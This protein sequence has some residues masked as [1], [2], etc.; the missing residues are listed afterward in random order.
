MGRGEA[1]KLNQEDS[2]V[3]YNLLEKKSKRGRKNSQHSIIE[4]RMMRV[5][6]GSREERVP[7]L[8]HS[9]AYAGVCLA[10]GLRPEII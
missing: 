8:I 7:R 5:V 2:L 9:R 3:I 10:A 1:V 4:A 6:G